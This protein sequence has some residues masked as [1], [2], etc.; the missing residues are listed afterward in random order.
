MALDRVDECSGHRARTAHRVIAAVQVGAEL[1]HHLIDGGA[2]DIIGHIPGKR[3]QRAA[4]ICIGDVA[5]QKLVKGLVEPARCRLVLPVM[6]ALGRCL[7]RT[8]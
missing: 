3:R 5:L 8:R 7:S 2:G 1:R 4:G 6:P